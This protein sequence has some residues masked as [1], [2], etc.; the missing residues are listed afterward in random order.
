MAQTR[1]KRVGTSTSEMLHVAG[2]PVSEQ[3]GW[4]IGWTRAGAGKQAGARRVPTGC[5]GGVPSVIYKL[6]RGQGK[7]KMKGCTHSHMLRRAS[8]VGRVD[9]GGRGA[10]RNLADATHPA[11]AAPLE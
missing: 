2:A 7:D 3:A 9:K 8:A 4:G 6:Q 10:V 11:A 5:E 1:S